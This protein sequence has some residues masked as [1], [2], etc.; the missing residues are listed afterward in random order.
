VGQRALLQELD[1]VLPVERGVDDM[2]E[3]CP[4]LRLI[5]LAD[6]LDQQLA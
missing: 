1:K 6:R 3:G 2:R 5:A 4:D